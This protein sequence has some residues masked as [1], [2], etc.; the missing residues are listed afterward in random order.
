MVGELRAA[1]ER[2]R[3]DQSLVFAAVLPEESITAA[4]AAARAAWR[5]YRITPA[6]TVWVF[7]SQCLSA[8]HSCRDAV[9][10]LI[11]W[12]IARGQAPCAA[13]TG[14]YR[15]ARDKLPEAVGQ[16]LLQETGRLPERTTPAEWRWHNRRVLVAD[17]TT[18]TLP[19]TPE[20][21][22][23]YPQLTSQAAGCG[24]PIV[25]LVVVFS[26]AVG[27]VLEMALGRYQGKRTGENSLLRT[28]RDRL[29]PGD[30][31]L[32]DR[33]F[34]GWFDLAL[35]QQDGVDA[36][37]RKHQLRA[38]DFRTGRRLGHDDHWVVWRKP[39]RPAWMTPDDYDALP[40]TL[41]LRELRLRVTQPGFRTRTLVVVTTLLDPTEYAADAIGQL[42][43]RRWEAELNLRSLKVVLQ[44]DH[45]RCLTPHRVRNEL[46]MHLIAYNL[47]RGVMAAAAQTAGRAPWTVSFKS[48]LQALTNLLPV[49]AAMTP[50]QWCDQLMRMI[51]ATEVG[52]RPDRSEP[53]ARKRRPKNHPPLREPRQNYRNRLA[54]GR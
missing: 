28:L 51:A 14:A 16:Q 44:M 35:W 21:Q 43:R 54:A 34:S 32:L 2:V 22:A 47:I 10:R 33:Y 11:A 52:N 20:N 3:R 40:E 5:G 1:V 13:A 15:L 48:A 42:Y 31:L 9:G 18:V 36:V 50:E 23:E 46:H 53:R 29:E 24:F 6:V 37:V 4:F 12:L 45:L 8:D 30:V 27:T 7:L 39:Q 41:T 19:D 49:L 25:R 38:T 17:G 26:L